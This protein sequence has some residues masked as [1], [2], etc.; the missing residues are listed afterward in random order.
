MHE[1]HH[2][3]DSDGP[4]PPGPRALLRQVADLP[5][6]ALGRALAVEH[7]LEQAGSRTIQSLTHRV[8][9]L[10]HRVQELERD[11]G[12]A[13]FL[14]PHQAAECV[15]RLPHYALRMERR[16]EDL[17]AETLQTLKHSIEPFE[18][19]RKY[20]THQ[21]AAVAATLPDPSAFPLPAFE[22]LATEMRGRARRI[23]SSAPVKGFLAALALYVGASVAGLNPARPRPDAGWRLTPAASQTAAPDAYSA[24]V[25]ELQPAAALPLMRA[26]TLDELAASMRSRAVHPLRARDWGQD[27]KADAA[28]LSAQGFPVTPAQLVYATRVLYFEGATDPVAGKD[29]PKIREGYRGLAAII[30]RRWQTQEY[31][32]TL[33]DVVTDCTP[34]VQFNCI[35]DNPEFFTISEIRQSGYDVVRRADKKALMDEERAHLAYDALIEGIVNQLLGTFDQFDPTKG[36]EF[37]RNPYCSESN[38]FWASLER[39]VDINSHRF[40]RRKARKADA[41][42]A[43][44]PAASRETF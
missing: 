31:G 21:C 7:Q 15:I 26:P 9:D 12:K 32:K 19:V 5:H 16:L 38:G 30:I 20:R 34:T 35:P 42:V 3:H 6:S 4:H 14:L 37:Y 44:S 24:I 10:P 22:D 17:G 11:V 39:T 13:V 41:V 36:A 29:V 40:Y 2:P 43:A 28:V 8:A 23:K 1:P 27:V 33:Y 25:P 18:S